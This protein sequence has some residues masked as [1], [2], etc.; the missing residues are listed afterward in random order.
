MR[1][2]YRCDISSVWIYTV[3]IYLGLD[4]LQVYLV[5]YGKGEGAKCLVLSVFNIITSS[6]KNSLQY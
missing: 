6:G 3:S 1:V 4:L 5:W 2:H